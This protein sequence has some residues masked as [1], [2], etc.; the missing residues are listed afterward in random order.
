MQG[1]RRLKP[2]L[3][4]APDLLLKL[5]CPS[6]K[7]VNHVLALHLTT[8]AQETQTP[9]A[10][11]PLPPQLSKPAKVQVQPLASAS[12]GLKRRTPTHPWAPQI[13]AVEQQG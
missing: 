12:A 2:F 6:P 1:P 3:Q 8:N 4:P 7:S 9:L 10:M 13:D 11:I 5:K